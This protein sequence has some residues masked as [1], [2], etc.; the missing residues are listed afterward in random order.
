MKSVTV[1][2]YAK[3]NLSLE[4]TGVKDGYHM[5]DS[6]V[7][8]IDLSDSIHLVKRKDKL[9]NVY[10]HGQTSEGI[11]PES[12]V[13]VKAGEAFV[14]KYGVSGADITI[15]KDIPMGGGL[16]GSSADA[17]G[18]L[19]GMAKLYDIEDEAGIKALAD[20]LGSDTGYMLRGGFARMTGRG[21]QVWRLPVQ[22]KLY[23]LL[24]CPSSAVSTG[25]CYALYDELIKEEKKGNTQQCIDSLLQGNISGMGAAFYNS[26]YLPA[27]QINPEVQ[28]ATKAL[29]AFSPSGYGMTGSGS[30]AFALFESR[31]L[32]EWAKSRYRGKCRAIVVKTIDPQE[33]Q[34]GIFGKLRNPYYLSEEEKKE[35]ETK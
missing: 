29:A 19:N 31:E 3:L 14:E 28:E 22:P 15:F 7:A 21:E 17:A 35:A 1:Q 4:I 5:L 13:A 20:G 11:P 26:L 27:C 8:S 2:S 32:C 16:G 9:V 25:K 18:V 30:C 34:K 24:L 10:M 23:F 33:E 6:L 12:N